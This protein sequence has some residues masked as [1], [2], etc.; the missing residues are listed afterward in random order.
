MLNYRKKAAWDLL[1]E[2]V[3]NFAQTTGIDGI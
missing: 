3:L 1:I 2:E